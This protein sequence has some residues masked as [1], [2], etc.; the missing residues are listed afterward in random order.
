MMTSSFRQRQAQALKPFERGASGENP[1]Q[2]QYDLQESMQ[3][4]VGI[5]RTEN[6]MQQALEKIAQFQ[7][8]ADRVGI[9]GHR[10]YNNGWHTALDLSEPAGCVGGDHPCCAAAKREPGRAV[11]RRLS[12]QGRRVG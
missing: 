12:Q 11:S 10:Q 2:I 9:A 4:L 8:R 1:Y 3:D 6:E 7:M 5:V